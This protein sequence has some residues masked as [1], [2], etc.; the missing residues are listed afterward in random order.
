MAA[1]EDDMSGSSGQDKKD[2]SL[3]AGYWGWEM[4]SYGD[5]GH[6]VLKEEPAAPQPI[7]P[8][9]P[10]RGCICGQDSVEREEDRAPQFHS[11]WCPLAR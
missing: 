11:K 1:Q 10:S 8:K 3:V 7:S 5:Y 6:E 9:R 4:G 2:D